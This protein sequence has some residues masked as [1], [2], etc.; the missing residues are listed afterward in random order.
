MRFV[1]VHQPDW[2]PLAWIASWTDD[3]PEVEVC[4]GTDVE[5]RDKWFAEAVWEGD[6]AAGELE[7]AALVYGSGAKLTA[8]G[9]L[10]VSSSHTMDRLQWIAI[11]G[12]HWV[13]NSLACLLASAAGRLPPWHAHYQRDFTTIIAGIDRYKRTLVTDR[14]EVH[15][16]Y[17][18]NLRWQHGRLVEEA[19]PA[20]P[21]CLDS[22]T[23]YR[24]Y[25]VDSL[26]RI[27][28][29]MQSSS[30]RRRWDYLGTVSTGFDSPTVAAL[31]KQAGLTEAITVDSARGGKGDSG[32]EIA[33]KLKLAV[34]VVP[35][36]RWRETMLAEVAFLAA[37]AK[38]EDVYFQGA[39]PLLRGRVLLTG[40]AA[41]AWAVKPHPNQTFKRADQSGLSLTEYRLWAGFLHLPLPTMG[42]WAYGDQIHTVMHSSD[43]AT[44]RSGKAYD[45]PFCRRVLTELGVAADLFG[46]EKKAASVLLFDRSSFLS[47]ASLEQ[48]GEYFEQL[49][50]Q[51]LLRGL[52]CDV[53][54]GFIGIG[55]SLAGIL[56]ATSRAAC[57]V[58]S[59]QVTRRVAH[60]TRLREFASWEPRFDYLFPWAMEEAKRRYA[61]SLAGRHLP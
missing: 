24:A 55:G 20:A 13:S 5:V 33:D 26:Q 54:N 41:G 29:N 21:R 1:F 10:F 4:H 61:P 51:S 35:R 48:F 25:L 50:R 32:A 57:R 53:R 52:Q 56:Q 28:E 45:K 27:A 2:P 9:A 40:Y 11:D 43:M 42:T 60:S 16:T 34:S 15:L 3:R 58:V 31:G 23:A 17:F 6:F 19:K 8:Q 39:E 44:W 12:R 37:D 14:G 30:R 22:Y 18:R 36:D 49:R 38:G 59:W 47:P 7:K 46:V